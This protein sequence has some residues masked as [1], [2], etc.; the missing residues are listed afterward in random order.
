MHRFETKQLDFA[1]DYYWQLRKQMDK[2]GEFRGIKI[3]EYINDSEDLDYNYNSTSDEKFIKSAKAA[4]NE[5]K[6][7]YFWTE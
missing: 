4:L 6:L 1:K 2:T 3:S 5:G 7:I